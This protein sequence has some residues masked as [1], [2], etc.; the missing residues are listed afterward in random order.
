MKKNTFRAQIRYDRK[1]QET[2]SELV[3]NIEEK[4]FKRKEHYMVWV[5]SSTTVGEGEASEVVFIK[6]PSE[7]ETRSNMRILQ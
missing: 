1:M 2:I 4:R 7:Y 6:T 3:E 5:T